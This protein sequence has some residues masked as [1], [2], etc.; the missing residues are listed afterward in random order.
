MDSLL[1]NEKSRVPT[2]KGT[3]VEQGGG[4]TS[5]IETILKLNRK[6]RCSFKGTFKVIVLVE[7]RGDELL[8]KRQQKR[9]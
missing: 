7:E 1:R 4:D 8:K 3:E 9:R 6:G 5:L 2:G